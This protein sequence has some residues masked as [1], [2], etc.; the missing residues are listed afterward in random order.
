MCSYRGKIVKKNEFL[1]I[2]YEYHEKG[3][4]KN[5]ILNRFKENN[6]PSEVEAID[7]FK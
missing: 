4:L 3:D 6:P 5:Y 2:F 7:L 1:Y